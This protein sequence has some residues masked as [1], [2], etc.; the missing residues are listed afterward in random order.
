MPV[1]KGVRVG[2]RQK[3]TPNKRSAAVKQAAAETVERIVGEMPDA[4]DGDA[5][6]L[7]VTVYKDSRQEWNLRIDAAK[8]AIRYE[9]PALAAVDVGNKDDKPFEQVMRWAESPSEATEDPS[10]KL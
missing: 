2:G 10:A 9:K 8:A 4:F 7:L 6:A 1:P 5:H 3:G